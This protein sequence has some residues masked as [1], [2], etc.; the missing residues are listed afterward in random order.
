MPIGI[1]QASLNLLGV[2]VAGRQK[3]SFQPTPTVDDVKPC[4]PTASQT[5]PSSSLR[6]WPVCR[7]QARLAKRTSNTALPLK[8]DHSSQEQ[9]ACEEFVDHLRA[10]FG[11]GE[12][13]WHLAF[14]NYN[15]L[16]KEHG[17]PAISKA[18]F[19]T[20]LR[21]AGC[22]IKL[23]DGQTNGRGQIRVVCWPDIIEKKRPSAMQLTLP[24]DG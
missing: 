20:R 9:S 1:I 11:E 12:L 23:R 15:K 2:L 4:A 5:E 8:S 18:N 7:A 6:A 3:P 19:S 14:A 13:P 24:F 21:A 16:A 10:E 17:W 22:K